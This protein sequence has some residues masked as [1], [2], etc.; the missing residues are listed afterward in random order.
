MAD[1][2]TNNVL[3]LAV[4]LSYS[5]TVIGYRCSK[6]RGII[7]RCKRGAVS[8]IFR[9]ALTPRLIPETGHSTV[10]VS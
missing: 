8:G 3:V 6:S 7:S 5:S 10:R 1:V 2:K 9:W 4:A